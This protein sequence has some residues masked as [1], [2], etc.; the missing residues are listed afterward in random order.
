MITYIDLFSGPGGLCTGFKSEGLIPRI[1]V[2]FSEYTVKTY[3][4]SHNAEIYELELLL[5]NLGKLENI[6]NKSDKTCVIH[7]DINNVSNE[8][9]QEILLKKFN[10]T[11]V[12]IVTGGAPCESFSMAGKRLEDDKR[13]DL[14]SNILRIGHC[15]DAK[16]VMFENVPG[17]LTK[18]RDGKVG[19]QIEYVIEEFER[20]NPTTHNH[21]I[22]ASKD[23]DVY[24]C[25][26]SD[27]GTP[28]KR[29]RL[30][31]VGCNSKYGD[32]PFVYPEKTHGK[33]RQYDA[34][35]V[36]DAFRYLPKIKSNDGNEVIEHFSPEYELDYK[37]NKITEGAYLYY[38]FIYGDDYCEDDNYKKN[39]VT[40]HKSLNHSKK[41][42]QRFENIKQG[43]G[44]QS[45]VDR[46]IKEGKE[47]IVKACFPN[48]I[49][50]SRNRRLK[51]NEPSYTV[52]SH[53]LDEMVHPTE[54]RQPTPREVARLQ[55]FPDWYKF[56]GPYVKFHSDPQQDKY[57]QI[58]DAIPVIM[59]KALAKS[60]KTAIK[61][62]DDKK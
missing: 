15:V 11:S 25:M 59:A 26:A 36:E 29:E 56:E 4:A 3:A 9:I 8:L 57:E 40:Y 24:K 14:F 21:Y 46:L 52:T 37:N 16:F 27:Y 43:E 60:F 55:G 62:L 39:I 23:K 61:K 38:K 2:D 12:D 48:K 45:A 53:C 10:E 34:I 47:D 54:D 35:T 28:Q 50:S 58:G 30:F 19:G 5:S 6:L 44:M 13:N 18:K 1:A 31:I 32:N 33:G 7:G 49:Y 42:I 20:E 17:L 51:N 22:L 41:M